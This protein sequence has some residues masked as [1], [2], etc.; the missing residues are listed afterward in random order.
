M[1]PDF[2]LKSDNKNLSDYNYSADE[3]TN[4][5]AANRLDRIAAANRYHPNQL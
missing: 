1:N 3:S 4:N 5:D 2:I